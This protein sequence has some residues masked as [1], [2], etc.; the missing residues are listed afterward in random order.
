M[1]RAKG[2]LSQVSIDTQWPYQVHLEFLRGLTQTCRHAIMAK[3]D[4]FCRDVGGFSGPGSGGYTYCFAKIDDA[5][6][7]HD[8]FGGEG[9]RVEAVYVVDKL[10]WSTGRIK[11]YRRVALK[12]A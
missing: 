7:F 9:W 12:A 4:N 2:A 1:T 11:E 5:L 10:G 6:R 8:L 3:A